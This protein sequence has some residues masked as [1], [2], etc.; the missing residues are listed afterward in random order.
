MVIP[1]P[2]APVLSSRWLAPRSWSLSTYEQLDGYQALRKALRASPDDI[3]ALVG[4]AKLRGRGG[5]GYDAGMKWR[6]LKDDGKPHYLVVNADEG[7]P[8]TCRDAPLM[9]AD[10]HSL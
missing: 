7:E 8:G 1:M 4:D 6:F 3:V 10:P 2:L 9:M 5:G